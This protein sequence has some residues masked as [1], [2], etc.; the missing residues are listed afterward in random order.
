MCCISVYGGSVVGTRASFSDFDI[1]KCYVCELEDR[2]GTPRMWSSGDKKR[3]Q[4]RHA[5]MSSRVESSFS[6]PAAIRCDVTCFARDT[7][8]RLH[9]YLTFPWYLH[10]FTAKLHLRCALVWCSDMSGPVSRRAAPCRIHLI[11]TFPITR[12]K[13]GNAKAQMNFMYFDYITAFTGN[14]V[15]LYKLI[16]SFFIS[17]LTLRLLMSYIYGAPSKARNANVVY[18]WTYVWQR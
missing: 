8:A 14:F 6:L 3:A 18:I 5:S 7:L 13:K 11:S 16:H 4:L 12:E 17:K 10:P 1:R 2:R 15:L 9:R